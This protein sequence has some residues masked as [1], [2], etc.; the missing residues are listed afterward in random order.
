VQDQQQQHGHRAAQVQGAARRAQDRRLVAHVG[1]DP[2]IGCDG[3][4]GGIPV[5]GEVVLPA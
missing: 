4:L 1:H 2:G 5:G 3:F